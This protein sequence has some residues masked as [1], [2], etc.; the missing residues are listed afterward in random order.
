MKKLLFL[1][2]LALMLPS[3]TSKNSGAG[4]KKELALAIQRVGEEYYNAGKYTAAL[5]SLL[6]A[7]KIIPDDPYLNNSLGL[8]YLAKEKYELAEHYFQRALKEKKDFV[9]A[10]NNLGAVYMAMSEWDSAIQCF[11]E[12]SQDILY[13]YPEIPLSNIGW[14][15]FD[16]KNYKQANDYFKKSL[17]IKADFINPIHGMASISI[18]T[19]LYR[20]A[21]KYL[22]SELKK[23]P[24]AV[25]LHSDLAR[26]YEKINEQTQA[27]RS[28]KK[29]LDLAPAG[30][31]LAL[32]AGKRLD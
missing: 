18:E 14:V 20:Q 19:G 26:A 22:R 28:W 8:S 12:V 10:K 7:Y 9:Y 27:Q 11:E 6:E 29:V 4:D 31:A 30:S 5:R 32:E 1:L 25:I 23:N 24:E 3:C 2:I 17:E 16:R 15:Y 13:P 21:I